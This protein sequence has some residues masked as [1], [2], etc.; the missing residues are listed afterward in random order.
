MSS[1]ENVTIPLYWSSAFVAA[2]R[3]H[4]AWAR[5]G[6]PHEPVLARRLAHNP[7][8]P[9]RTSAL[10][11]SAIT[12]ARTLASPTEYANHFAYSESFA[13]LRC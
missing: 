11:A 4:E 13:F 5:K 10:L 9:P 3:N 7:L 1:T 2:E 12:V 8:L 6:K